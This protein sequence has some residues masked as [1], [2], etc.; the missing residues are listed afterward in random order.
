MIVTKLMKDFKMKVVL[1]NITGNLPCLGFLIAGT[2]LVKNGFI[3]TG[4]FLLIVAATSI[5]SYKS[6]SSKGENQ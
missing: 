6:S 4:I 2:Y 5:I 3:K 1:A